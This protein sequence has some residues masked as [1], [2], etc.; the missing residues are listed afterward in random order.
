MEYRIRE[1]GGEFSIEVKCVEQTG[2]L[3]WKKK[4][5]VWRMTNAFGSRWW[6]ANMVISVSQPFSKTFKTLEKAK[7]QITKWNSE[8]KYHY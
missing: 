8:V 6:G 5:D 7:E 3:W 4:E 1:K 2:C